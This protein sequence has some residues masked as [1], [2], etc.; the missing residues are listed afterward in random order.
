MAMQGV[1]K[2]AEMDSRRVEGHRGALNVPMNS[3]R[4]ALGHVLHLPNSG[5]VRG[6]QTVHGEHLQ[7]AQADTPA[8]PRTVSR[9]AM[10]NHP[11]LRAAPV[12][13]LGAGVRKPG[14]MVARTKN[15]DDR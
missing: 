15:P 1:K 5:L 10:K 9:T 4:L 3:P 12:A 8:R 11:F 6:P 13:R 2:M 7:I 14:W